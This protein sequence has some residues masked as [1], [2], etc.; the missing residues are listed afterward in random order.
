M[1]N[2]PQ[3]RLSVV[4]S[5]WLAAAP[6]G[7]QNQ[8]PP[9]NPPPGSKPTFTLADALLTTLENHP[10]LRIQEQQV[11]I[12]RALRQQATG[13]FDTVISSGVG[14]RR[15]L[16]GL[17]ALQRLQ[18]LG[19]GIDANQQATNLTNFSASGSKL[20]RNGISISPGMDVDRTTDNL[21]NSSGLNQSRF[22]FLVNIPLLRGRGAAVVAARETSAGLDIE[23]SLFD[24]NQT[25]A[26]LLVNTATSYWNAVAAERQFDVAV[27]SEDRG[28]VFVENVRA[29]IDADK[30]PRN[31]IN[32][33]LANFADRTS[34][35]IAAVQR[36]VDARQALALAMGL[37]AEQMAAIGRPVDPIP[38]GDGAVAPSVEPNALQAYIQ[39]ALSRR[40]DVLAARKRIESTEV[41]RGA[42][43]NLILPQIDL[44]LSSGYSGLREGTGLQRYAMIPLQG[45]H[46]PDAAAGLSYR[47]PPSNNV[48]R[49]QLAQAEASVRQAQLFVQDASRNVSASVVVSAQG[50]RN[51]LDRLAKARESVSFYQTALDGEREKFR[52]GVGSLVDT[53][54]IEDRLTG[55]LSSLVNAELSYATAL[56]RFRFA[57]GTVVAPNQTVQSVDGNL[58]L[59]LPE[60][61]RPKQP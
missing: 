28:R 48:A 13:Q 52:I 19:S 10:L 27:G 58:F 39:L 45:L 2:N 15:I 7:A 26:E 29:L 56:A 1:M 18:A 5:V 43:K 54:T 61:A 4:L 36:V 44:Q 51:A 21:V 9:Q 47:F 57:T 8:T 41:L 6:L 12:S 42:A 53:L 14:Q 34:T 24:L 3:G 16:T 30:V 35:R 32:Q 46:G 40:A 59:N 22:S 38:N 49:G 17:T 37:T 60:E 11:N 33:V 25:V 50:V 20:F 31:E 23:A 55:A